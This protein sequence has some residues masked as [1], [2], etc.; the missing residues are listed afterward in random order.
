MP[1]PDP[2][3]APIWRHLVEW[4]VATKD[5]AIVYRSSP[6]TVKIYAEKDGRLAY[7]ASRRVMTV[8]TGRNAVWCWLVEQGVRFADIAEAYGVTHHSVRRAT[9]NHRHLIK[10]GRIQPVMFRQPPPK[11]RKVRR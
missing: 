11:S 3:L 9:E 2:A 7:R 5:I 6:A 4:G 8:M 1:R 10:E